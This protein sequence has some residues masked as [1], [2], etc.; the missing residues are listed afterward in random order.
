MNDCQPDKQASV[1]SII[2]N[3]AGYWEVTPGAESQGHC[4]NPESHKS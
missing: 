1:F 3:Q 2:E 4:H